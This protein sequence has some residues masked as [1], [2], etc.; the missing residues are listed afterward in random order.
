MTER[1][2]LLHPLAVCLVPVPAMVA[3][4]VADGVG[5]GVACLLAALI[6]ACTRGWR[7]ALGMAAMVFA[8]TAVMWFGFAVS[9]PRGDEST[10]TVIHWLPLQ[11]S[12]EVA[13]TALR[14]ALR[15]VSIMALFSAT[16]ACIR[17]G[18]LADTLIDRFRVPYRVVDVIGLGGR[19]AVLIA[20]DI[21]TARSLA[22]LRSRGHRVRA[23]RLLA[24]LTV[25][26]LM[27]PFAM[28]M[29]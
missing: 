10:A 26:V 15:I 21:R 9:L 5:V 4:L 29:S 8:M 3:V 22:R 1:R 24:G 17:W 18:V 11:P 7:F 27:G 20:R 2:P 23:L 6:A 12:V 16:A 13:L 25:P 19:F 28:R 14:G